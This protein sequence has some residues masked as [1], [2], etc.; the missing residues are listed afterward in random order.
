MSTD[1]TS[2]MRSTDY[3]HTERIAAALGKKLKGGELIE[4]VSDLGGGKTTFV[5]GLTSGFG[6]SD[7]VASPTF[8]ISREYKTTDERNLT[9]YHFDFY[10][11]DE[12]GLVA[13][14]LAEVIDDPQAVIAIEWANIVHDILPKEH[15]T[16]NIKSIG[17]TERDI[18]FEYPSSL[19]YLFEVFEGLN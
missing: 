6:S 17:V 12:P 13:T 2:Q 1:M 5:R 3:A 18:I 8:T 16:V 19:S 10:R 9:L 11:L 4:L 7:H 15:V 14:E